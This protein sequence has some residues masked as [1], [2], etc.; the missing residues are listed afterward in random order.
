VAALS[1]DWGV[2]VIADGK[3]VWADLRA[4]DEVANQQPDYLPRING[5]N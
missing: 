1:A 5:V 4:Q 3:T 2:E